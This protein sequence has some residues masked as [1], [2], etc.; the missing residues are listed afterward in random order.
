MAETWACNA[1]PI[2]ALATIGR[3]DLLEAMDHEVLVAHAVMAEIER[4][5]ERHGAADSV[6]ASSHFRVVGDV[7]VHEGVVQWQLDAGETQVLSLALARRSVGVI[8]DDLAARRCAR[9]LNLHL[10]GTLGV[11]ARSRR[12]GTIAAAA[13]IFAA[14]QDSG[15]FVAATLVASVLAELGEG[16]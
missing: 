8:I 3:L 13:P 15:L 4:G 14:L 10:T 5:N 12:L 6:R 2:I 16:P 11:V 9:V 1:S 7:P